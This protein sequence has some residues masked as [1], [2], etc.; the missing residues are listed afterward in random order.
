MSQKHDQKL[1]KKGQS[2]KSKRFNTRNLITERC[3]NLNISILCI[4]SLGIEDLSE[5][6]TLR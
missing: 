4:F 2:G 3:Y 1:N 5:D 6:K